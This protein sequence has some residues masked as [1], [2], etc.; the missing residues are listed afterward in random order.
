MTE[1]PFFTQREQRKIESNN[2]EGKKGAWHY[3]NGTEK[4][5]KKKKIGDPEFLI[6]KL[7]SWN[8]RVLNNLQASFTNVLS[9]VPPQILCIDK[10]YN[11]I[12]ILNVIN[13][14]S[15]AACARQWREEV[16]LELISWLANHK[17][18][19]SDLIL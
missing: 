5:K 16:V 8:S 19:L 3:Q 7:K 11:F 17:A 6:D 4:E 1:S 12:L 9:V 15:E 13:Q 18:S 14:R 2:P 10:K